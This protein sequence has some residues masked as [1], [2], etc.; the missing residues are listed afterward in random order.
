MF[1]IFSILF[2]N[3]IYEII[4]LFIASTDLAMPSAPGSCPTVGCT[5]IG[6]IKGPKYSGHHRL[7]LVLSAYIY[8]YIYIYIYVI[9]I[10]IMQIC[11]A[12]HAVT[13]S[14]ERIVLVGESEAQYCM[15]DNV[16]GRPV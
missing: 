5:G 3:F 7:V 6:H 10:I 2:I 13:S 8:I 14:T 12:L 15:D 16:I 11:N 1:N 4:Y 9:I